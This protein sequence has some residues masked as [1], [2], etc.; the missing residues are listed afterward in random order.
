MPLF[1]GSLFLVS[2]SSR[3]ELS[4]STEQP[5]ASF[6]RAIDDAGLTDSHEFE[7]LSAHFTRGEKWPEVVEAAVLRAIDIKANLLVVDTL[8][9]FAGLRGS[10][11][12]DSGAALLEAMEPL[13]TA[14]AKYGL[15]VL[16][17]R[18][19]RKGNNL[20]VGESS[21]GSSA[22]AGAV[23]IVMNLKRPDGRHARPNQRLIQ[24][25]SRFSETPG[26]LLIEWIDGEYRSLGQC[27]NPGSPRSSQR[28]CQRTTST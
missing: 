9:Q 11:E 23:D 1:V 6:R 22:F 21:R 4:I 3:R 17:L 13:Q 16:V 7:F 8:H 15:G 14:A 26:N 5:D 18:H 10:S 2:L 28:D 20:E 12:N 25:L 27:C 24:T 19:D